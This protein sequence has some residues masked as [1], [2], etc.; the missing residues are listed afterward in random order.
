MSKSVAK[1]PRAGIGR[2]GNRGIPT[3]LL[4]RSGAIG[5]F[6]T[7]LDKRRRR[8]QFEKGGRGSGGDHGGHTSDLADRGGDPSGVG[9]TGQRAPRRRGPRGN[10]RHTKRRTR[11]WASRAAGGAEPCATANLLARPSPVEEALELA[12]TLTARLERMADGGPGE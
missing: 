11:T 1:A 12:R 7:D 3:F 4:A 2:E 10:R 5:A 6:A 9:L 8:G